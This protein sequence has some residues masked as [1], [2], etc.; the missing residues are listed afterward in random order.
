[1]LSTIK[2][3]I[4][5]HYYDPGFH[6]VDIEARFKAA[7]ERIQSATSNGQIFAIIAQALID[8]HDSHTFFIPPSRTYRVEYG[9]QM[10]MIG[11]KCYVVAVKPGS[12][13]ESKGLKPGDQVFSV[14]G[15]Q[16]GRDI[17]WEMKYLFY[18]LRPA[19]GLRLVLRKGD[20]PQQIDVMANVKQGKRVYDLTGSNGGNDIWD[21]I[22]ESENEG[23]LHRH[24]TVELK[25]DVLIWK[26]PEF[27]LSERQ[28]DEIIDKARKRKTLILDLRGNPGGSE[29]TL[30]RLVG[31]LF[32][33]DVKIGD[34]KGRKDL[35]PLA[36]KSRGEKAFRGS[37]VVLVDSESGSAA[38]VLARV[39]QL[40]KRGTVVGDR[41]AGAVMRS[42]SYEH[43][44]GTD[45][46]IF[47]AA[48]ITDADLV[49]T[50]GKSL[51]G[52]GVTPDEIVLPSSSDLLTGRDPVLSRATVL[53]GAP[54]DPEKAGSLFPLE[55]R[56]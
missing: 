47:Y 23:R 15:Y 12:D 9:W 54:L 41:S 39:V 13:A 22:R 42:E 18:T 46:V 53:V 17:M 36:A 27:D 2:N 21:L 11:D 19:P 30:K 8:L 24:T 5:K 48:S 38:E 3:D 33:H 28:V 50:D 56:K 32:D 49:M 43:Q 10:R 37:L 6:G 7:E 1:M 16:P 20:R 44:L 31:D 40:E 35:K 45:T 29:V 55:W 51:E 26:M 25:D 14:S 4:Q 52:V 34:I